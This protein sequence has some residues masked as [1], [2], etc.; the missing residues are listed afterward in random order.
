M[1]LAGATRA[2][3]H[4]RVLAFE[5][6]R[7]GVALLD[8]DPQML[9]VSV[10][11]PDAGEVERVVLIPPQLRLQANRV[12]NNLR[13]LLAAEGLIDRNDVGVAVLAQ[14][15][16]QLLSEDRKFVESP[17]TNYKKH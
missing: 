9:R 6:E 2:F 7:S 12:Q 4:F 14:L 8:G 11:I 10:T 17:P 1:Q 5:M 15:V 3:R 13:E 16:R